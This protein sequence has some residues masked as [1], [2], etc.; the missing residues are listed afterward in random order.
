ML[1][2]FGLDE[3]LFALKPLKKGHIHITQLAI[4][5]SSGK[6]LYLLQQFNQVVF[7][8]WQIVAQNHYNDND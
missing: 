3:S 6:T 4:E 2:A 7:K 1:E 5:K 8:E